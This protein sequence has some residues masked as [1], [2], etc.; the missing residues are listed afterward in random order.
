MGKKNIVI[1]GFIG[2]LFIILAIKSIDLYQNHKERIIYLWQLGDVAKTR[3]TLIRDVSVNDFEDVNFVANINWENPAFFEKITSEW[4]LVKDSDSNPLI[5]KRVKGI[6]WAGYTTTGALGKYESGVF[7]VSLLGGKIARKEEK[8]PEDET[9]KQ[10][11]DRI[12]KESEKAVDEKGLMKQFKTLFG[13]PDKK[14]DN[15]YSITSSGVPLTTIEIKM[16]WVKGNTDIRLSIFKSI[17]N[18]NCVMDMFRVDFTKNGIMKSLQ[19][20]LYVKLNGIVKGFGEYSIMKEKTM[21]P[22][23]FI[24]DFNKNKLLN[25]HKSSIADLNEISKQYYEAQWET[26]ELEFHLELD[27][28]AKTFKYKTLV[29]P[30]KDAGFVS[31]GDIHFLNPVSATNTFN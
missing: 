14:V 2:V 23:T 20:L 6:Q 9:F 28:L 17:V 8:K 3:N 12:K 31:T 18:N 24:V 16:Q 4:N 13:H 21:D 26:D 5:L 27:M 29:L 22:M 11:K 19:D 1:F 10:W 30:T 25:R 7:S 15:S